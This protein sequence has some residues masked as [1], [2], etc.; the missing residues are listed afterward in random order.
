MKGNVALIIIE[1][2]IEVRRIKRRVSESVCG[3]EKKRVRESVWEEEESESVCG[4]EKKR[5]GKCMCVGR[6]RGE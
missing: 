1:Q 4:K 3:K 5:V 2:Y 6:K